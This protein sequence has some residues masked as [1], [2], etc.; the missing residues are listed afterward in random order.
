[1]GVWNLARFGGKQVGNGLGSLAWEPKHRGSISPNDWQTQRI[2]M[3]FG[4][5]R[6]FSFQIGSHP[7]PTVA[8]VR[9]GVTE[10][11]LSDGRLV[12][13]TLHVKAVKI[14]PSKPGAVDV[15]YNVIAEMMPVP[16]TPIRDVHE[17]IQ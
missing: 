14:D 3:K 13:A 5:A 2:A 6:S 9:H 15:S 1:V 11:T 16:E 4:Y 10:I 12:R 7:A 17:T 8:S